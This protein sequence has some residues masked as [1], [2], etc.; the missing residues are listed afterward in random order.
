VAD[1]SFV[2]TGGDI[3]SLSGIDGGEQKGTLRIQ[4][5][6]SL[7]LTNLTMVGKGADDKD[8]EGT[9][10]LAVRVRGMQDQIDGVPQ[11]EEELK[12][13]FIDRETLHVSLKENL[14]PGE[15]HEVMQAIDP[16]FK[17]IVVELNP[18]RP[19]SPVRTDGEQIKTSLAKTMEEEASEKAT[20]WVQEQIP[21]ILTQLSW[22]K[23]DKVKIKHPDMDFTIHCFR[24]PKT[25]RVIVHIPTGRLD[26]SG[27]MEKVIKRVTSMDHS[28][29]SDLVRASPKKVDG[30]A[31]RRKTP[32]ELNAARKELH[33]QAVLTQKLDEGGVPNIL[34]TH[35][36]ESKDDNGAI[37]RRY[38]MDEC[39][40]TLYDLVENVFATGAYDKSKKKELLQR[41]LSVVDAIRHMHN[42][43]ETVSMEGGQETESR[44]TVH[45]DI[46][47]QNILTKGERTFLADFGA[48]RPADQHIPA[49]EFCVGSPNNIAPEMFRELE[50]PATT[51]MDMWSVGSMLLELAHGSSVFRDHQD[52]IT[53]AYYAD[54]FDKFKD[55]REKFEAYIP[56][57]QK[58]LED[59]KDELNIL[60]SALL[61]PSPD[62]R[63]TADDAYRALEKYISGMKSTV[64]K[65]EDLRQ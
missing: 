50:K 49:E 37:H 8:P 45:L 63:P 26:D 41:A 24:E 64:K 59:T 40:G 13:V 33:R 61:S 18:E 31:D 62:D 20:E 30:R 65:S 46:K 12:A 52:A 48:S 9:Q 44:R 58:T 56:T 35:I 15:L 23:G 14:L 11:D 42:W 3:V 16:I 17:R 21:K 10:W 43:T 54:D 60:I 19:V 51:A 5:G 55:E 2:G 34:V 53:G 57:V 36:I 27:N 28:A 6:K 4:G 7:E 1:I 25:G 47:L 29:I 22:S 38:V 32:P 39:D